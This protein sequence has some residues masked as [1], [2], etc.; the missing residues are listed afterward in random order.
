MNLAFE[1]RVAIASILISLFVASVMSLVLK[2]RHP[3][4]D[5]TELRERVRTWWVIVGFFSAAL[6]VSPT[7]AVCFFAFVS[8]LALKEF[9]SMTPTRRSDRRVLFYAYLSIIAQYYF[10][11]SAWYGMFIV[12]IPVL[13]FVWLPTRMLLMGQTDGFLRAAGSLHWA[14]MITVFSLSH[15]AYLLTFQVTAD[16]RVRPV[17]P[18]DAAMDYPGA[19]LLL[20]LVLLTELND[21]FQYLWGKSLGKRKVA[22]SVSPGKT[23][24]GLIGGVATTI[25]FA[26]IVGPH[27]TIMDYAR[28]MIAGIII[29][30]AGFAGDLC[31]SAIKRDL[32]IKDFGATLPG[33]GG[34]LDRVDSLIFTAPLFFH[35]VYYTYG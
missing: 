18:S 1:V 19:G 22:P 12:F 24:A 16:P 30:M 27:L 8:F 10:A 4:R 6:F 11:A 3:E 9:L 34:V 2:W 33:H 15:V 17:F 5:F 31:M 26:F 23:Y 28:S 35:F 20:F 32:N 13:M 7:A 14:L 29:G 25:V 21:I